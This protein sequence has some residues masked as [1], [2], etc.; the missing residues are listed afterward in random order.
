[1]AGCYGLLFFAHSSFHLSLWNHTDGLYFWI[2]HKECIAHITVDRLWLYST[3]LRIQKLTALYHSNV[4]R[5]QSSSSIYYILNDNSK[6]P[7]SGILKYKS[8]NVSSDLINYLNYLVTIGF[9]V[10]R[11]TCL[12]IC[13]PVCN[14]AIFSVSIAMILIFFWENSVYWVFLK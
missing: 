8:W 2:S 11:G 3:V 6:I 9:V 12:T 1:M 13:I 7:L 14:T 5:T 4:K 10:W